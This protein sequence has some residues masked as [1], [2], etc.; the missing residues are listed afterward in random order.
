MLMGLPTTISSTFNQNF[1][2]RIFFASGTTDVQNVGLAV[3]SNSTAS[4]SF[5]FNAEN[6]DGFRIA[7][8]GFT[9]DNSYDGIFEF[10]IEEGTQ[11]SGSMEPYT[12]G[13]TPNPNYPQD[14]N[15]A[16]GTI[17]LVS[18]TKNIVDYMINN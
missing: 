12:Y 4:A 10:Q 7:I 14:I 18:Q 3:P 6:I 16:E 5:V 17:N 1:S 8:S 9:I 2:T 11:Y 13:A 15:V